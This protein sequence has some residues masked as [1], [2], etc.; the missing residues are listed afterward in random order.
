M[1]AGLVMTACVF[2]CGRTLADD[3]SRDTSDEDNDAVFQS[4]KPLEAAIIPVSRT[5]W[6]T[7]L[8]GLVFR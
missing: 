8:F 7:S 5:H 2:T 1:F 6:A 3:P 4:I